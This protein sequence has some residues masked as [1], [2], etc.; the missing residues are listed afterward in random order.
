MRSPGDVLLFLRIFFFA[1][2]TPALLR[3]KLS[4]LQSMLE[5]K[6]A[7]PPSTPARVQRIVH[8]V[9]L[10]LQV[11]RP[12]IHPRCLTRCLT[13]YY[14]L[15][16]AGLDVRRYFGVGNAEGRILGHCWLVKDG[17][18]FTEA[19]DPRPLF[20]KTYSFPE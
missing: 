18:P 5:P 8:Y 20:V 3:L 10:A 6:H 15:R 1:A 2:A 9:D 11:G 19:R 17:E 13:L 12:L 16:R 14:F 7:A 4:R